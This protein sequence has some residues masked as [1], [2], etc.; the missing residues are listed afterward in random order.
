MIDD[1]N[2]NLYDNL[3]L[4]ANNLP[5]RLYWSNIEATSVVNTTLGLSIVLEEQIPIFQI[6]GILMTSVVLNITDCVYVIK[7]T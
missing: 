3:I 7:Q 6:N 4:R 5:K 1:D 2:K